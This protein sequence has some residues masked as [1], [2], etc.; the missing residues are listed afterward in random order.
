MSM[1]LEILINI[2]IQLDEAIILLRP[3]DNVI[4]SDNEVLNVNN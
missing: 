1:K 4:C 3:V 2:K